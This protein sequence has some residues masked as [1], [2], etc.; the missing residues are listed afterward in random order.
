MA[1]TPDPKA[2]QAKEMYLKGMKLAD[3]ARQLEKPEGT[4]RR[5]KHDHDW[6]N[7]RSDK[8]SERSEKKS[9]RK[10]TGIFE[11]VAVLD[12][13]SDLP[14]KQ[15]LFCLLYVKYFNAT[16]AYQ[17]AYECTYDSAVAN[18]SRLLRNDN[19]KN[20]IKR[21]KQERLNQEM[22]SAEDVMQKYIDIAFSD[23]TDYVKFDED[24][25]RLK[26]SNQVDGTLIKEVKMGKFGPSIKLVDS[27]KGL[28]WLSEHFERDNN[29]ASKEELKLVMEGEDTE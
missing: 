8:K 11:Q 5:W 25:V 18:G 16:K 15:K 17:K 21:L 13:E 22:L 19:V 28:K 10:K 6:D 7:E 1:R 26:Q 27:T 9:K 24:K 4:I 29:S 20:E 23:I 3:I 14:D 2:Q 12:E